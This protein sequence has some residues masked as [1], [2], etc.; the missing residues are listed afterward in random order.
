MMLRAGTQHRAAGERGG[1]DHC[2]ELVAC[3]ADIVRTEFPECADVGEDVFGVEVFGK[4]SCIP[5][6]ASPSHAIM[7]KLRLGE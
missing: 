4:R 7:R 3:D 1:F 6:V 2:F 5:V